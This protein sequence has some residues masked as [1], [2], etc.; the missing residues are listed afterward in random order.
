[1]NV[2]IRN[3]ADHSETVFLYVK[4]HTEAKFRCCQTAK[5]SEIIHKT[6]LTLYF[7]GGITYCTKNTK[8]FPAEEGWTGDYKYQ[9][10]MKHALMQAIT[11]S[12][13]GIDRNFEEGCIVPTSERGGK[14]SRSQKKYDMEE[15]RNDM[16]SLMKEL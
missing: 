9:D 11:Y 8:R 16:W 3:S 5:G 15:H 7:K 6:Q 1:M 4:D 14:K 12:T 13:E 10:T 2:M